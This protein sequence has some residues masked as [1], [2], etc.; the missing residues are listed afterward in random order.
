MTGHGAQFGRKKEAAI[1]ALLSHRSIED[2]AQAINIAPRTLLRWLQLPEFKSSYREARREGVNQAIGRM[3]QA[4]ASAGTIALKLIT[5]P[6]VPAAFR[7]R[8]SEFVFD[9]SMRGVELDDI[10][11]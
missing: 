10:E 8:A 6:N 3:K 9:R 11:A 5:D 7:L 4:T 2:A 1:A